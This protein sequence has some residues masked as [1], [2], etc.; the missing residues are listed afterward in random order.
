MNFDLVTDGLRFPE[1]PVAM[2]DGS[3]ILVEI[4]RGTLTRVTPDGGKDVIAELGGGPNGAAIGP[5]GA[6][7]ICNNGGFEWT[8]QMGLLLPGRAPEDYSGGRIERVDLETGEVTRLYDAVDGKPLKGPNDIVFDKAGNLYF[9]DHGKSYP[10]QRD[11]GGLYFAKPDGSMIKE[12]AY[13]YT[14]PNG[15]GLSPD[16]TTVYMAD[17]MTGRLWAFDLTA[18]GEV[19]PA[20]PLQPGRVVAVMPGWTL[21]DSLAVTAAGNVCVATLVDPGITT[22]TPQGSWEKAPTADLLTTNICFGGDDMQDAWITLSGTGQLV[23]TRWPEPGLKLTY[24]A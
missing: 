20:S 3:I 12:L 11:Y 24:N 9:T 8:E 21:F 18:P 5:D 22:I 15:V 1:G 19:A 14:S 23:K 16:E 2:A 10:R 6:M 13:G 7:Y 4:E 17:T